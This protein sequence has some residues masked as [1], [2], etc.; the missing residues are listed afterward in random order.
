MSSLTPMNTKTSWPS[1]C[2]MPKNGAPE[3]NATDATGQIATTYLAY[4]NTPS[5][6]LCVAAK[7]TDD[8]LANSTVE[9]VQPEEAWVYIG[10]VTGKKLGNGT[11]PGGK[12]EIL[13]E[14]GS[15]GN[16]KIGFESFLPGIYN[17]TTMSCLFNNHIKV[18]FN[19]AVPDE[20][21]PDFD[22]TST[23]NDFR[24]DSCRLICLLP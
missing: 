17:S 11:H 21:G 24:T 13:T 6:I 14:N 23:G 12:F 1:P 10:N 9:L 5:H 15:P 18:H 16:R 3:T 20:P 7:L 4:E 2:S 8:F 22:T 19:R